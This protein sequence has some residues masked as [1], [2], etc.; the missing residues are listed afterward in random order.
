MLSRCMLCIQFGPGQVGGPRFDASGL[1][2]MTKASNNFHI[3][4]TKWL[5][6]V[7]QVK[8]NLQPDL[9]K[10]WYL[11]VAF[12]KQ[13]SDIEN[14]ILSVWRRSHSHH[15]KQSS[16]DTTTN[17]QGPVDLLGHS[18]KTGHILWSQFIRWKKTLLIRIGINVHALIVH[19]IVLG[20]ERS[21]FT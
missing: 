11:A 6:H 15:H 8:P 20:H 19:F 21:Q 13:K 14:R 12:V 4:L 18:F 10:S 7:S 9:S 1:L 16:H 3:Y 17:W 2:Q 5:C